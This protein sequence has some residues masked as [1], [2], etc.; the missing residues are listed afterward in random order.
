MSKW[1]NMS[2]AVHVRNTTS[3]YI[4]RIRY[5][6][7]EYVYLVVGAIVKPCEDQK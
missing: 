4:I 3:T 2:R 5:T 6:C 7:C 1:S